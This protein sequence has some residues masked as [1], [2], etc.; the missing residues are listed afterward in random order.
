M[1]VWCVPA[2]LCCQQNVYTACRRLSSVNWP[3][4]AQLKQ[5]IICVSRKIIFVHISSI[6]ISFL[7]KSPRWWQT[8]RRVLQPSWS[9][10]SFATSAPFPK[11]AG[12]MT[13][14]YVAHFAGLP[15]RYNYSSGQGSKL[16][17]DTTICRQ[18]SKVRQAQ[19]LLWQC[20]H[21]TYTCLDSHT[22]NHLTR[23]K[24]KRMFMPCSVCCP[25]PQHFS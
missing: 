3:I 7:Y 19:V 25:F 18:I 16:S 2:Q 5:N 11:H 23:K 22:L 17:K 12:E 6:W 4:C 8:G 9:L 24:R 14:V 20:I 10:V 15:L 21:C 13:H 1:K